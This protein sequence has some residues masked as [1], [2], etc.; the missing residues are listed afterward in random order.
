MKIADI[1]VKRPIGVTMIMIA[2]ILLGAI[3]LNNLAIDLYPEMNLPISVVVTEYEGAAPQE[4]EKMVTKTLE[5]SLGTVEGINTL[6]SQSLPGQS[7]IIMQFDWGSNI[8]EK[9][10]S[11]R[12][13]LDLVSTFLPEE[14]GKPLVM[15]IDPTQMPIMRLSVSGDI[16]QG[17]LTQIAEDVI[18]MA[19]TY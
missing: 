13:K 19:E 12:E 4:V 2:V 11:I 9:A 14:A 6:Q 1:S 18:K 7:L 16:D 10:N 5:G 15:N 8:D 3:S 17:R